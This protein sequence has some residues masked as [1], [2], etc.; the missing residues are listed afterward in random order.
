VSAA[1]EATDLGRRYGRTWALRG[2]SAS[3]PEGSVAALVGPNGAGKTTLL[4]LAVGLL[5][6]TEGEVRILGASMRGQPAEM[7]SRV[8]FVAQDAPLYR[9]FTVADM[10]RFGAHLNPRWDDGIARRRVERLDVPLERRCGTLSGGQQA[11]V[12]LAIA[13]AKRPDV[14]LL[15]EPVARLDPLARREFLEAL[16]ETVAESGVTVVLSS[17]LISDLE[18]VC[19]H[20]VLLSNGHVV[21]AGT[22]ET[23]L[24]EHHLVSGPREQVD[25]MLHRRDVIE[26]RV[27][28]RQL[29]AMV[30]GNGAVPDPRVDV[31]GV[32]LE[33]LVLAYLRRPREA[34]VALELAESGAPQ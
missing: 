27:T 3:V 2:C 11:Q 9:N 26:L 19:D 13:V 34:G 22:T 8:G 15:D 5:E 1:I 17:H 24:A 21:I 32:S 31:R 33:E 16:M 25:M 18:R 29:T 14:L 4:E 12:A 10:L 20:L 23:L 28:D 6:A 7:L 30:R